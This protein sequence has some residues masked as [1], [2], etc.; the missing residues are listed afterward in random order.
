M[1]G[2]LLTL[3]ASDWKR[4]GHGE[5]AIVHPMPFS[6]G[7]PM[8][9]APRPSFAGGEVRHVGDIVAAVVAESRR[10]A[11]EGAEAVAVDY[12]VLPSVSDLRAA[13]EPHAPLV[14]ETFGT[15]LVFEIERGDREKTE[16]AMASAAKVVALRLR[17]SRLSANPLEPRAY[18]CDYDAAADRYTLYATT[19]QPHYL[20]RWHS[21]TRCTFPSTRFAS[22][23]PMSAAGL[24]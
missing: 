17:N 16:A 10:A 3:T 6:D 18:L 11:E 20:R 4:A 1:P 23:R 24:A 5:L 7:R 14:H 21:S 19:Q 12:E 15:N 22:S 2:V 13:V 9:G 8:N